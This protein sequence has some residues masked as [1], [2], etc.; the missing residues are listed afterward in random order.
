MRFHTHRMMRPCLHLHSNPHPH[1]HPDLH[2]H[3]HLN[4]HP[5]LHLH[6]PHLQLNLQLHLPHLNLNPVSVLAFVT[7][8]LLTATI[9]G[10]TATWTAAGRR[11]A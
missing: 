8:L 4:L 11:A 7:P 5:Q 9:W 2:L 1:P 10:M 3:L 6:L